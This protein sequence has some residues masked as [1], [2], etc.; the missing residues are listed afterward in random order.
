MPW[1]QVESDL[2][3]MVR[4]LNSFPNEAKL[5]DHKKQNGWV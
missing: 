3:L 4:Y 2:I 1:V 5:A